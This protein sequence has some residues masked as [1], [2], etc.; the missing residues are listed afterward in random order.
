M[1]SLQWL[2]ET[3]KLGIHAAARHHWVCFCIVVWSLI[4]ANLSLVGLGF[5]DIAHYGWR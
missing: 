3:M 1:K 5:W 4:L 2:W